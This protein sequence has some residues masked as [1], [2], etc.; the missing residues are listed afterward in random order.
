MA[1][2]REKRIATLMNQYSAAGMPLTDDVDKSI[3]S[4]PIRPTEYFVDEPVEERTA[5]LA[6]AT[7]TM[8][9]QRID[10]YATGLAGS[11]GFCLHRL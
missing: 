8:T 11:L 7:V 9:R 4:L 2:Q 3:I 6:T 1:S 10:S 5:R